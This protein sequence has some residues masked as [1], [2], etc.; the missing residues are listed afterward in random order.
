MFPVNG[1]QSRLP[2]EVRAAWPRSIPW[3]IVESWRAAAERNHGQ[4][5]ERLA[6]RGGLAP[7]ELYLAAHGLDLREY[8]RRRTLGQLSDAECGEWL[9]ELAKFYG[10]DEPT[11]SQRADIQAQHDLDHATRSM[12]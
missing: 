9:V 6:E 7:N 4:T 2:R 3:S 11:D 12:P 5:L 1:S 10:F 8:L